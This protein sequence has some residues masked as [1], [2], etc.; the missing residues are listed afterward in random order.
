MAEL[1][2]LVSVLNLGIWDSLSPDDRLFLRQFLPPVH[3]GED[4]KH[5]LSKLFNY[6]NFRFGNPVAKF[7]DHLKGINN[8]T[9]FVN[10]YNNII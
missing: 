10:R 9:I 8:R 3:G 6:E 7:H 1:Q 4:E 2:S 5:N